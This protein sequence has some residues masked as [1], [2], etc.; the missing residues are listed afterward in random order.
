[1]GTLETTKH[2]GSVDVWPKT[3]TASTSQADVEAYPSCPPTVASKG[4]A[5][6]SDVTSLL[7]D[8]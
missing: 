1:M 2:S 6:H 5:L 8:L 4:A 7:S 3:P